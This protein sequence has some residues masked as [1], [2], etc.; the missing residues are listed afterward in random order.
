[1]YRNMRYIIPNVSQYDIYTQ[2]LYPIIP[3][4][5]NIYLNVFFIFV[6]KS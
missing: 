1:M 2:L 6:D 4:Y 3:M 5:S